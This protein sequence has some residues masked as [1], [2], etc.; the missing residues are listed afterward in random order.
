MT[1]KKGIFEF[2]LQIYASITQATRKIDTSST[3]NKSFFIIRNNDIGDLLIITPLFESIK[4]NFPDSR[5]T[6]GIGK[7]NS[8]VIKNN[9]FI[10]N[11]IYLS[12]PW[13]NKYLKNQSIISAIQYCFFSKEVKEIRNQKFDIG[14]DIL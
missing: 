11:V 5:I 10:D 6:V 12:A 14:I 1:F 7:W 2:F 13:H 4:K 9:P 8:D 3:V